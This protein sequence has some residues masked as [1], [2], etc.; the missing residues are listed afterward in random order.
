MGILFTNNRLITVLEE[1]PRPLMP[2]I[3]TD[4]IPGQQ[5]AHHPI[6]ANRTRSENNMG[7]IRNQG[8][9]ETVRL[10][11]YPFPLSKTGGHR[12]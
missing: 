11:S 12:K 5:P 1:M 4:G 10:P 7:V 6:D 2:E 9:C 8:P 3:K